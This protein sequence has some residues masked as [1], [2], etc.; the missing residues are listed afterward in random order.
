ML[1][2]KI[3]LFFENLENSSTLILIPS[4]MRNLHSHTFFVLCM[5]RGHPNIWGHTNIQVGIQTFGS[6]QTYRWASKDMVCIQTYG[7]VQ[8]YGGHPNIQGAFLH[9][10][11]SRK[12]GFTTSYINDHILY[13]T[14][15]TFHVKH[16]AVL[17]K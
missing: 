17:S 6:I 10:F 14:T 2:E 3:I 9:A 15:E 11:L 7:S 1:R 13:S 12:T 16:G 4:R 8:T 5:Y